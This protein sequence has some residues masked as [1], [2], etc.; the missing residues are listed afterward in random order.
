LRPFTDKKLRLAFDLFNEK[1]FEGKIR[2]SIEVRYA[3]NQD[4]GPDDGLSSE[5]FIY[6]QKDFKYHPDM[7]LIVLLHEM[8]HCY[9][10]QKGYRAWKDGG[11]HHMLFFA[12]L[13][14][15]YKAGAYE[16][17]L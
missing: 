17:L 2:D 7:G 15:L 5:D 8:Q 3:D 16:G 1:Y 4:C 10:H 12:G 11:G 9:M 14:R 6:I 13:D